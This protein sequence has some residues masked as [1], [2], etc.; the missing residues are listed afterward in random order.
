MDQQPQGKI[1]LSP[2][3]RPS[4]Y[5]SKERETEAQTAMVAEIAEGRGRPFTSFRSPHN[6]PLRKKLNGRGPPPGNP[7]RWKRGCQGNAPGGA[8]DVIAGRAPRPPPPELRLRLR[9]H[10]KGLI[11]ET[12]FPSSRS[13]NSSRLPSGGGTLAWQSRVRE[14]GGAETPPRCQ[15]VC[16]LGGGIRNAGLTAAAGRGRKRGHHWGQRTWTPPSTGVP[17]AP[18]LCTL[19]FPAASTFS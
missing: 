3:R 12:S 4:A 16:K 19:A 5:G 7:M 6:T 8:P 11:G 13:T 2:R 1:T 15:R 18:P 14:R 10:E 17:R 9:P